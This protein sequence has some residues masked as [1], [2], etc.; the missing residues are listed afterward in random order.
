MSRTVYVMSFVCLALVLIVIGTRRVPPAV[1]PV[2]IAPSV[3]ETPAQVAEPALELVREFVKLKASLADYELSEKQRRGVWNSA[4]E[5]HEEQQKVV[6][7]LTVQLQEEVI[8]ACKSTDDVL[9][10]FAPVYEKRALLIAEQKKWDELIAA[11]NKSGE[12]YLQANSAKHEALHLLRRCSER[13]RS[14]VVTNLLME[15]IDSNQLE[16]VGD[17]ALIVAKELQNSFAGEEK[18]VKAVK[19]YEEANENFLN[20][21]KDARALGVEYAKVKGVKDR[22][23]KSEERL[24]NLLAQPFSNDL[25][26]ELEAARAEARECA[27]IADSYNAAYKKHIEARTKLFSARLVRAASFDTV[28]DALQ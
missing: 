13:M 24:Q 7:K 28:V 6:S 9:S 22:L 20:C 26:D 5:K 2:W 23:S 17:A 1:E 3:S 25:K 12:P 18:I 19:D 21:L 8:G 14:E 27:S 11:A 15:G 16:V 4:Y 10:V